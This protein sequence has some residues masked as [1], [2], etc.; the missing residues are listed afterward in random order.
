MLH[1]RAISKC[2]IA[3]FGATQRRLRGKIGD[4]E[5]CRCIISFLA[6]ARRLMTRGN[7]DVNITHHDCDS[8]TQWRPAWLASTKAC[9]SA[10]WGSLFARETIRL[11]I[12]ESGLLYR[13]LDFVASDIQSSPAADDI[14]GGTPCFTTRLQTR[15]PPVACR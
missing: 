9:S 4:R 10:R 7:A 6:P 11:A 5:I 15:G 3:V 1:V 12:F 13:E 2:R 14:R 8:S